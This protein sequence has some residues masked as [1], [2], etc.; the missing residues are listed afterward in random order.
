MINEN[1]PQIAKQTADIVSYGTVVGAFLGYLPTL[2]AGFSILW[3][4]IQIWE[5]Q[6]FKRIFRRKK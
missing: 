4:S 3:I 2:A 1:I 6:T 5:S